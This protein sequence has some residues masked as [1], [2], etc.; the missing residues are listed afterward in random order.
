MSA[1]SSWYGRY[2]YGLAAAGLVVGG[3]VDGLA[4]PAGMSGPRSARAGQ[5]QP[6]SSAGPL[7]TLRGDSFAPQS[8]R[9]ELSIS[10]DN[11]TLR[12]ALGDFVV[13]GQQV[14]PQ[15]TISKALGA[16]RVRPGASQDMIKLGMDFR[17][18]DDRLRTASRFTTIRALRLDQGRGADSTAAAVGQGDR[19]FDQQHRLGLD[20]W[21]SDELSIG[22][23]T[24]YGAIR[25]S[26]DHGWGRLDGD[27]EN[28]ELGADIDSHG[29]R[30]RLKSEIAATGGDDYSRR[31]KRQ[32]KH[33]AELAVPIGNVVAGALDVGRFWPDRLTLSGFVRETERIDQQRQPDLPTNALFAGLAGPDK[34]E[35]AIRFGVG[36]QGGGGRTELGL[37]RTVVEAGSAGQLRPAGHLD[38]VSLAHARRD[39]SLELSGRLTL[40]IGRESSLRQGATFDTDVAW[41]PAGWPELNA[42]LKLVHQLK[43]NARPATRNRLEFAASADFAPLW[44]ADGARLGTG[45]WVAEPFFSTTLRFKLG[46]EWAAR[47]KE[48]HSDQLLLLIAGGWRF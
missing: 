18:L 3:W 27:R 23:S 44:R 35:T 22:L 21:Q 32:A 9:P 24:T 29:W 48:D 10:I 5:Q 25:P 37:G 16:V 39:G 28:L 45:P 13:T 2:V 40:Q 1:G 33:L 7:I 19:G 38:E 14:A 26:Y 17:L 15:R 34:R 47:G 46:G 8:D 41:R 31:G 11:H 12:G 4:N 6:T 20:L 30:L 42:G 36:W 43:E